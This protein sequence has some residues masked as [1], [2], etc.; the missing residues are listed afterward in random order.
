MNYLSYNCRNGVVCFHCR[1]LGH[2]SICPFLK[3]VEG[4]RPSAPP[5]RSPAMEGDFLDPLRRGGGGGS[6]ETLQPYKLHSHAVTLLTEGYASP[7]EMMAKLRD[8]W[9][10]GW[11][12]D[13]RRLNEGGFL[14]AF[15]SATLVVA[16]GNG[17]LFQFGPFF[18]RF[19]F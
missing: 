15:P 14:I 4:R 6:L 5:E 13:T 8:R 12:W 2:C 11:L 1:K 19:L 3:A 9:G 17:G 10:R 7:A 16:V 18:L